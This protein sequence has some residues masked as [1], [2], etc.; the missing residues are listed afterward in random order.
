MHSQ[1]RTNRLEEYVRLHPSS[2]AFAR[3]AEAYWDS[4]QADRA[5][6]LLAKGLKQHPYYLPARILRAR[7]LLARN[8]PFQAEEALR[9]A[10]S[11]DPSN[12]MTLRMLLELE[13][14]R[15]AA[16][17][18][19]TARK[20]LALDDS[21]PLAR[22]VLSE[23]IKTATPFTTRSVAELYHSQGYLSEAL[24]IYKE[25]AR[26]K[27]DDAEIAAK[28]KQLEAQVHGDRK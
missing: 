23:Q 21:D 26:Q 1:E 18:G 17:R 28:I 15:E 13:V 22:R 11:V 14:Q 27:P 7:F 9:A 8:Q 19:T 5:L 12:L 25:L 20:L 16:G 24:R 10:L 3:V 2:T 4:G 6:K